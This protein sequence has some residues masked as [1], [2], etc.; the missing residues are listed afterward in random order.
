[1]LTNLARTL[2]FE[3]VKFKVDSGGISIKL[4]DRYHPDCYEGCTDATGKKVK[5]SV[6]G[7]ERLIFLVDTVASWFAHG[8]H[9]DD[10]DSVIFMYRQSDGVSKYTLI[11][12]TVGLKE[13]KN[14]KRPPKIN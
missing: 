14:R 12:I 9:G 2:G 11:D 7:T 13:P 10:W 8:S 6:G 3:L 5:M 4:R 1:M